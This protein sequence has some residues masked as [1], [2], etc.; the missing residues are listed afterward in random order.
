MA[1][2][3]A[4]GRLLPDETVLGVI[5][6]RLRAGA[7]AGEK[8]YVLDGFPRTAAQA[9]A[10]VGLGSTAGDAAGDAGG[11]TPAVGLAVNLSLREE[12]LVEKCLGRR[13]CSKCGKGYNVADI[14]LPAQVRTF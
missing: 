11:G 12:V 7:A 5:A 14:Y 6:S 1:A 8:G 2:I 13:A 9:E 4:E 3:V 10:L